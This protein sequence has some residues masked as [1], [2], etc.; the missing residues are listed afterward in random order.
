[1]S[2]EGKPLQAP[3]SVRVLK[4]PT[5][6][7]Y[8]E[9]TRFLWGD[10]QSHQV[11]DIIYGRGD[12][13]SPLMFSL[14][15]GQYFRSSSVWRPRYD[16]DRFYYVIQGELAIQ[17]PECGEVALAYEGEAIY[18]R[19]DKY[20]FGY[21]FGLRET[22]VLDLYA[23][24]E[25][26]VQVPEI[27]VSAKK[28]ELTRILNGRF[29]LLGKWPMDRPM[30]EAAAW[31]DGGMVTLRRPDALHVIQ[32]E[33]NPTLVSIFV[34]SD[35]ITAGVIDLLPAHSSEPET[36]PGDEVI[37]V[38][39]GRLNVYLPDTFEWL[40]AHPK[41]ALFLPEGSRHQYCN[42]SDEPASLVFAV[43]PKYR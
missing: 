32:G 37:F 23:P 31:R 17:D 12:R 30:V 40:E 2:S 28:P 3:K 9:A 4:E 25:R 13:L 29:E 38:C 10:E 26:P 1:M 22:L 18:W 20:H 16:Q 27:E 15:P 33:L 5:V 35:V 8:S 24:Q 36:H 39:K 6:I 42:Y 7:R 21:N 41:D 11:S 19:G 34:S 14:R 43:S